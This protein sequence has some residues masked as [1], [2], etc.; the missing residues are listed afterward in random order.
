[1]TDHADVEELFNVAN[2]MMQAAGFASFITNDESGQPTARAVNPFPP[3]ENFS[4]IVVASHRD[5]RK[6]RDVQRDG[7]AVLGYIDSPDKGYVTITCGAAVNE[8]AEDKEAF[9]EQRADA[10]SM[11]WPGGPDSDDYLLIDLTP[12]RVEMR[13]YVLGVAEQPTR[14]TPVTLER[15]SSGHWEQVS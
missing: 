9:W 14:W 5:T 11:F 3:D 6:T 1:M 4:R 15:A 13:S 7:R 10:F 12:V 8:R 2:R